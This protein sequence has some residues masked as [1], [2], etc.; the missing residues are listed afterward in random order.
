MAAHDLRK[1]IGLIISYSEFLLEEAASGLDNEQAE[2]L[3][4]IISSGAYMQQI[5]DDFL[6]VSTIEA[7]KFELNLQLACIHDI[8]A[9]SFVLNNLQAKKKGI[10]LDVQ[11]Q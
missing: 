11:G 6:D 3:T 1:P 5:V 7:G 2:F 4:T 9:R 10:N 8:L